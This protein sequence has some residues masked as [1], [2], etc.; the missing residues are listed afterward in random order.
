MKLS[1]DSSALIRLILKQQG[2]KGIQTTLR[3]IQNDEDYAGIMA[4]PVL[5]EVI[6]RS[7]AKGNS[8]SGQQIASALLSHG[9]TIEP[10]TE[11]DLIRAA[12]LLEISEAHPG[13]PKNPHDGGS[14]LS[15]ADATILAI[16]ERHKARILT[17]DKHWEWLVKAGLIK[18]DIVTLP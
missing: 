5:T 2:W 16:S 17:A 3:K 4:G 18:H 12:D 9:L 1:F 10:A 7:R 11:V 6:A 15:L 8:S 13:P 14:T